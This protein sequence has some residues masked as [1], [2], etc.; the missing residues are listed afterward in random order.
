[1]NSRSPYLDELLGETREVQ[2]QNPY[3]DELLE[4][5]R[6]DLP[7][8]TP[9]PSPITLSPDIDFEI[10]GSYVP[11]LPSI[12]SPFLFREASKPEVKP[13]ASKR[14]ILSPKEDKPGEYEEVEV[15][16]QFITSGE[17]KRGFIERGLAAIYKTFGKEYSDKLPEQGKA[18]AVV[19]LAAKEAGVPLHQY[20]QSPEML[21]QAGLALA[22]SM[23]LSLAPA[24]RK[25]VT[26]EVDYEATGTGGYIGY[27]LGALGGLFTAPLAIATKVMSPVLK[28]IPKATESAPIAHRIILTAL[29]DA[30]V[31]GTAMGTEQTGKALQSTT[32]AEAA[33]NV[34]D[35]VKSGVMVG[36]IFGVTKGMFP[37][38]V[39]DRLARITTGLVGLNAYRALEVGGNPFTN[40]PAGEVLFDVLLD[41][42]F[43]WR[44]LPKG[45]F[46]DFERKIGELSK[47]I[48]EHEQ[49]ATL[50]QQVP[51]G[52][53]KK[54]QEA[55]LK[56]E[57]HQ[58]ELEIEK[59]AK[60]I[61]DNV[62]INVEAKE[63][64][65]QVKA[66]KE[67]GEVP[68]PEVFGRMPLDQLKEMA[69]KGVE[70]AK[71]ELNRRA[72]KEQEAQ[73]EEQPPIA[74]PESIEHS[75]R[76]SFATEY[77]QKESARLKGKGKPVDTA[78]LLARGMKRYDQ[79]KKLE[80]L[81]KVDKKTTQPQKPEELGKAKAVKKRI[82]SPVDEV[83]GS[84]PEPLKPNNHPFREV[85]V[86]KVNEIHRALADSL[87]KPN[88]DLEVFTSYLTNEVN[89]Y[90]NG[91]EVQIGKVR[92]KLSELA[93][94][95]E[96]FGNSFERSGDFE[97][98][99][100]RIAEAARWA[101]QVDRIE[102]KRTNPSDFILE[103]GGF[104]TI[105]ENIGKGI[106][107]L[108]KLKKGITGSVSL[109]EK[110]LLKDIVRIHTKGKIDADLT[111]SKGAMWKGTGIDPTNKF[112]Q[113]VE[114][115]GV[116]K[117]NTAERIPL[118]DNSIESA[119]F[120]PPFIA[121][122]PS[123]MKYAMS[124][125]FTGYK[126]I[127]DL[128]T[129]MDKTINEAF[130]ILKPGGRLIVKIQDVG[131]DVGNSTRQNY[132]SSSEIYNFAVR[133]GFKPVDRFI[134]VKENPYLPPGMTGESQKMAR[135]MH[136]DYWILEKPE[137]I[138]KHPNASGTQLNMMIPVN[139]LP[140]VIRNLLKG[141]KVRVVDPITRKVTHEN[142]AFRN[143]EIFDKTGFWLGRDGKWR[144]EIGDEGLKIRPELLKQGVHP[145]QEVIS[146]PTLYKAIP[147]LKSIE[148][149]LMPQLNEEG[150]YSAVQ[151]FIA[152]KRPD[153]SIIL[154][155]LQHAVNDIV[156]SKFKGSNVEVEEVKLTMDFLS[157][158][159]TRVTDE[160]TRN[161][162]AAIMADRDVQI[163]DRVEM[164]KRDA[165]SI[166]RRKIDETISEFINKDP[167]ENYMKDPGEMEARLSEK[168][169][170][171]TPEQRKAEPP[172]ETLETMLIKENINAPSFRDGLRVAS[173][174]S[175]D[176]IS[177]TGSTLYMG[178]DPTQTKRIL[179]GLKESISKIGKIKR[180]VIDPSKAPK[181][182]KETIEGANRFDKAFCDA[183]DAKLFDLDHFLNRFK[184]ESI[185][186]IHEQR[187]KLRKDLLSY[188]KDGERVLQR[189]DA[190]QASSGVADR[191]YH[192]MMTEAYRDVPS[193]LTES[194]KAVNLV[195]R[196]TAIYGYKTEAE[197]QPPEGMSAKNT[198]RYR[199][200]LD[201]YRRITPE[202]RALAEKASQTF[203]D[204]VR[205]WVDEMVK[206]GL[207]SA[208]EGEELKNHNYAKLRPV[209][210]LYDFK[211]KQSGAELG[212]KLIRSTDSGVDYL[213]K[214]PITL[215]EVD[216]R[217]LYKET[218]NRIFGRVM[219][220]IVR[221][222]LKNFDAEHL[223]N[224]FVLFRSNDSKEHKRPIPKG[225][226]RDYYFEDGK[227]KT[228][229]LEPDFAVQL[230]GSGPHM[231]YR[232]SEILRNWSGVNL[233]RALTVSTSAAWATTRGLTMDI[234]HTFFSARR[235]KEVKGKNPW[236]DTVN[237]EPIKTH[238][239]RLYSASA[240]KFLG[241]IGKDMAEV[242]SDVFHRGPITGAY[243]KHGGI[244]PFLTSREQKYVGRGTQLSSEYN[245]TMDALSFW[246]QSMEMW[247]RVAVMHRTM[248]ILA[249]EKGLTL[250]EA[251]KNDDLLYEATQ[252]AVERLPYRQG[253][254]L[255]KE[256]DKFIGP[257]IS[258][259]Y[260][261]TRTFG[262]A[263]IENPVDFAARL[264]N[265]AIPTVGLT[266]GLS[267]FA[268]EVDRDIPEY[269]H[270]GS[271]VIPLPFE[272]FSF[273]DDEGDKRYMLLRIPVD[274]N[275]ATLY[276]IFRLSTKKA[277]YEAG[278]IDIE[279]DYGAIVESITRSLPTDSPI[280]PTMAAWLAYFGNIDTW[281]M[282]KVVNEPVSFP[283]SDVE[284][285]DKPEEF[286]Q[287]SKDI[288]AKTGMS[289]PRM[290]A[291]ARQFGMPNNEYAWLFGKAY[292][293]A[294][295]D[296]DP[297]LKE[298]HLAQSLAKTPGMKNL[299]AI[300]VPRAYR[301]E[302]RVQMT[303]DEVYN[304]LIRN[305][306]LSS[307]AKA[308]YWKGVGKESEI[309]KYID[310]FEDSHVRESLER[311]KKFIEDVKNLP[312]RDSWVYGFNKSPEYKAEDYYKIWR[313]EK[314]PEERARLNTEFDALL[315]AGY[316]TEESS[317][318]FWERFDQLVIGGK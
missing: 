267:L 258:A 131:I 318:R 295:S 27:A 212:D 81:K 240:P 119:M 102:P 276:N 182:Y 194:V 207:K 24:V 66:I 298:E 256:L 71:R 215:Y 294:M 262:R 254:W 109:N 274:P 30:A 120:D 48:A 50:L 190:E 249:G 49:K 14:T 159:V 279:P 4:G 188:G 199:Q 166:D 96:S 227:L 247:N 312:H 211:Y 61:N 181:E 153:K 170:K 146:H 9:P 210:E 261:A 302:D 169:M 38:D 123:K 164:I 87:R 222:E 165:N 218:A 253:G 245:R 95:A 246:G 180:V 68:I 155:E 209:Q 145:I 107:R 8:S 300:T 270:T 92:D 228:Y 243:A 137:K 234:A 156:G 85:N 309:E 221:L 224:P 31:L 260:N 193:H 83:T 59:T 161:Q 239:E 106:K 142:P 36:T 257:F 225:W 76:I 179:S 273:L 195:N 283:R 317:A 52:E 63:K 216:P 148:I 233:T 125:R 176:T 75:K 57:R 203:F 118:E 237:Y 186:A 178:L 147:E 15:D 134:N 89:R 150:H 235:F 168:R 265:L 282:N 281:R 104:Q 17:Y 26:G 45:K 223:G 58:L 286:N 18:Q 65:E 93:S 128:W 67:T 2:S 250:E 43:L 255:L 167:H 305:N 114:T 208:K 47:G 280:G 54:A 172:W 244:I 277:L 78:K 291:A 28:L 308:F 74:S 259:G 238:Y 232:L 141:L 62:A 189:I 201:H 70:G 35:G 130:R 7:S 55:A 293:K 185:R 37:K 115:E 242:K 214:T 135:K 174:K 236:E 192:E 229:Y 139:E 127:N 33:G 175:V 143:K 73:M 230:L 84:L 110:D 306:K 60:D 16:E 231:S 271:V 184:F 19:Q 206:V 72:V 299:F 79:V 94:R 220:Q 173:G 111:Y 56:A 266:I 80:S 69:D 133:A 112:D 5:G 158:L 103:S 100:I 117:A 303:E 116:I 46:L 288:A 122:Q 187:H 272:S 11:G 132:F 144:Y 205:M 77:M 86:E 22:N 241:Q 191:M 264:S 97:N 53:M 200:L 64:T 1:M 32:F 42:A 91:G 290:E 316:V 157:K 41:V 287:L 13:P 269:L 151:R 217:I 44:G 25:L 129:Y 149:R 275:V 140:E 284:G 285:M 20:R 90:L 124:E 82:T 12:S 204:H 177:K 152:I 196:L 297:K 101:R 108:G 126:N 202:E 313:I 307:D 6:V 113:R 21:E 171:M 105:Y 29:R 138:Y 268:P 252:V 278:M 88:P 154:H 162:I 34:W 213:D 310:S 219:N 3:L 296:L 51:E 311:Q 39:A 121:G 314:S 304:R 198:A 10:P 23:T 289:A 40:R 226:V 136:S 251:Y 248:K 292:D 197:F 98:W 183:V 263:A 99:R 301:K 160:G 163:G 315:D